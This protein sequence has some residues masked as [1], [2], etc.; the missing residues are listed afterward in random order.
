MASF[1]DAL[2][3]QLLAGRYLAALAIKKPDDS[4]ALAAVGCHGSQ[5]FLGTSSRSRKA[6]K[7]SPSHR[8][9]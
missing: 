3:K 1:P 9:P 4:I 8:F 2:V 6:R 7:C 5:V